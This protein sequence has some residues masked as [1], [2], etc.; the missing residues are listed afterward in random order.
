MRHIAFVSLLLITSFA[1]FGFEVDESKIQT[2]QDALEALKAGNQRFV[3]G[4]T[5]DQDFKKQIEKTKS[6]QA[7]YAVILSCLDSR[8]PPEIVFDQGI[9]DLFVGRVAGNIEDTHMLGSMEFATEVVGSRLLVVLGHTSCGAV[10]GACE[11]VKLDKLTDLLSDIRPAVAAVEAA[12]PGEDVCHGPLVDL[13]AEEN[14][15]RTIRDIRE[16]SQIIA[17]REKQGKLM[18]VGAMY[19]VATGEVRF[20]Q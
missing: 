1:A 16:K 6:G 9:G 20:L 5:L 7:P 12:H 3:S 18:V 4:A 13:A 10:I 2:P 11:N 15:R 14:V 19:D 8:V 17:D